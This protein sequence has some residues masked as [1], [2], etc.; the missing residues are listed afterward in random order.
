V[1]LAT[2]GG[3]GDRRRRLAGVWGAAWVRRAR[4]DVGR[5]V[6]STGNPAIERLGERGADS[7]LGRGLRKYYTLKDFLLTGACERQ[8]RV[9]RGGQVRVFLLMESLGAWEA[10]PPAPGRRKRRR[11]QTRGSGE[12]GGNLYVQDM[13]QAV[14]RRK[15]QWRRH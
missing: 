1:G 3:E 12:G 6:A 7:A 11:E 8:V 10:N 14:H 15:R 4:G 5:I 9:F 13:Q 2:N